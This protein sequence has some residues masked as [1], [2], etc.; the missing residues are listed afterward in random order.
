MNS[1]EFFQAQ[2]L[3]KREEDLKALEDTKKNR[4]GSKAAEEAANQFLQAKGFDLTPDTLLVR[5][6]CSPVFTPFSSRLNL[7]G[8]VP[9]LPVSVQG[10]DDEERT[11]HAIPVRILVLHIRSFCLTIHKII[12][13]GFWSVPPKQTEWS[14]IQ[15]L[16]RTTDSMFKLLKLGH[17]ATTPTW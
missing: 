4:L 3:R 7:L 1:D 2:A 6:S 14:L 8:N 12:D 9:I 10:D 5:S 15:L 16:V 13:D 17:S 11:A